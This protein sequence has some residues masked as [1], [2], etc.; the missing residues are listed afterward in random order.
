[1]PTYA[2]WSLV[3]ALIMLSF[4]LTLKITSIKLLLKRAEEDLDCVVKEIA[5]IKNNQIESISGSPKLG[6]AEINK[7]FQEYGYQINLLNKIILDMKTP[8]NYAGYLKKGAKMT[9]GLAHAIERGDVIF[10]KDL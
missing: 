3:V 10:K 6:H 4:A 8:T 1:M 5:L 2:L 9:L 7:I